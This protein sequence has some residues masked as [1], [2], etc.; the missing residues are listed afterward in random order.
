VLGLIFLKFAN[1]NYRRHEAAINAEFKKLKGSRREKPLHEIAVQRCGFY[2][3]DHA[4]YASLL[5]LP[6]AADIA[7]ALEAAMEAIEKYTHRH[8]PSR[9]PVSSFFGL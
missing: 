4:R 8:Y 6:E 2:L 5:H 3:P 1:I 9:R 7:K